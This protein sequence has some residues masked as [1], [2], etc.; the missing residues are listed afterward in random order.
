MIEYDKIDSSSYNSDKLV[1][2]LSKYPKNQKNQK[3]L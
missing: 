2:N 1:K 3:N